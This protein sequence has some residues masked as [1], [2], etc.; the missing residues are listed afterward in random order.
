MAQQ[1]ITSA[2]T[3]SRDAFITTM[4]QVAASVAVVT[5]DGPLP[6]SSDQS[7]EPPI[8]HILP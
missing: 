7:A 4:R 1:Q 5:T 6:D 3:V 2:D 8:R